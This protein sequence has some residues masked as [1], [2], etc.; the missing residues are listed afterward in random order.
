MAK[1]RTRITTGGGRVTAGQA[2][3]LIDYLLPPDDAPELP[4]TPEMPPDMPESAQDALGGAGDGKDADLP[5]GV[6][7]APPAPTPAPPLR[8]V[9]LEFGVCQAAGCG[10]VAVRAGRCQFCGHWQRTGQE[11]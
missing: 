3:A 10:R 9:A 2:Q 6:N 11:V 8:D 1:T 4:D 7:D 5:I